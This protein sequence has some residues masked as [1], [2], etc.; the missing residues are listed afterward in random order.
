MRFVAAVAVGLVVALAAMGLAASNTVPNTRAGD[1]AGTISG[2]TVTNVA[3]T[4]NGTNP[5]QVDSVSFTLDAAANTVKVRLQSGGT[6]YNCTNTSGNN[7]S[8]NTTG[9][10]VQPADELRVVAKSN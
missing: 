2:Y 3:Y 1:G 9:Q 4:L 10:A 6:W 7:W 8:C 5:Q